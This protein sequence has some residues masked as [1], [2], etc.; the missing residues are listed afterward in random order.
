[1]SLKD[2]YVVARI[3][4]QVKLCVNENCPKAFARH[5]EDQEVPS[6]VFGSFQKEGI[7]LIIVGMDDDDE[8]KTHTC[9]LIGASVSSKH[10]INYSD[11]VDLLEKSLFCEDKSMFWSHKAN[12]II[13]EDPIQA[14]W[15]NYVVKEM[16]RSYTIEIK[17]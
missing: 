3:S 14:K 1:M 4:N 5:I 11:V 16:D 9:V 15:W 6:K 8:E 7:T 12:Y 10:M 2:I 13:I 17:H